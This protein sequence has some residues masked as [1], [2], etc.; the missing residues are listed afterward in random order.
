MT[1]DVGLP[2]GVR[3]R[4]PGLRREEVAELA[5][6]SVDYYTRLEQ[7]RGPHPSRQ[8]LTGIQRALRL[9]DDERNHLFHLAGEQPGPP[10][11]PPRDI[12]PGIRHLLDRLDDAAV[13]VLDAKYEIIAWNPLAAALLG[14]FGA[15]APK[16]RN[17]IR[18]R[19]LVNKMEQPFDTASSAEFGVLAAGHLR[20]A[21]ARYPD[22]PALTEL[23]AELL[24]GSSEFAGIWAA[25]DV[26][27]LRSLTKTVDHALVGRVE[28]DCEVLLIPERDQQVIMYTAEPASASHEALQELKARVLDRAHLADRASHAVAEPAGDVRGGTLRRDRS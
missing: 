15:L 2:E 8:V 9:S 1:S 22:D 24:A 16:D 4:T 13:F 25:H 27:A 6:I 5:A 18:S 10:A 7:A 28:L 19:F 12:R 26:T 21:S 11:T 20:A 3:R 14:D 23:L 17:L